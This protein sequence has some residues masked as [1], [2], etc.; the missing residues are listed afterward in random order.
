MRQTLA[1]RTGSVLSL[2]SSAERFQAKGHQSSP[3]ESTKVIKMESRNRA[4]SS[5]AST[6]ATATAGTVQTEWG[7]KR[8]KRAGHNRINNKA[9]ISKLG[10]YGNYHRHYRQVYIEPIQ[11]ERPLRIRGT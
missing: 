1:L 2:D 7:H 6:V 10:T 8:G 9:L 5:A 11:T 4:D 3:W